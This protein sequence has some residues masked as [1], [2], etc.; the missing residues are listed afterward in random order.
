MTLDEFHDLKIWHDLHAGDRPLEGRVWNAVLTLWVIGWVGPPAA[1]LI[2]ADLLAA[3]AACLLLAPGAYVAVRRH[4]H[5]RGRLR[6]DWIVA[7]H[8]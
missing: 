4:L 1:W 3:C 6:C 5:R 7:L 8:H 2:G